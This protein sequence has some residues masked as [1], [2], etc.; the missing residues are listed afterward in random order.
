MNVV[1]LSLEY[2]NVPLIYGNYDELHQAKIS[3]NYNRELKSNL[4]STTNWRYHLTYSYDDD[5]GLSQSN[6]LKISYEDGNYVYQDYDLINS[7][8]GTLLDIK[9]EDVKAYYYDDVTSSWIEASNAESDPNIPMDIHLELSLKTIRYYELN[10]TVLTRVTYEELENE[11]RWNFIQG[12]EE[13][14]LEWVYI[15]EL[16]QEHDNIIANTI[17]PV[18]E[19]PFIVKEA[20]RVR[21]K[22]TKYI[23]DLIYPKGTIYYRVRPVGRFQITEGNSAQDYETVK[24]GVWSYHNSTTNLSD[25]NITKLVIDDQNEFS[26]DKNWIYGVN[27]AEDGKSVTTLGYFDGSLRG[28]QNLAYNTSDDISLIGESKFDYEGR[29]TISVI[30]APISGRN[31]I[32]QDN[33]NGGF[34]ASNFDKASPE[35]IPTSTNGSSQYFSPGNLLTDDRYRDRIPNAEGYVYSQVK[36][37]KDATGRVSEVGGIGSDF[38]IGSDHTTKYYY[39]TASNPELRRLFGDEVGYEDNYKKNIVYDANGQGTSSLIDNHGR[40]IA[41]AL[42]GDVADNLLDVD[43][44]Q[45]LITAPLNSANIVDTDMEKKSIHD[46]SH[47]YNS[48]SDYSF[49]YDMW[50]VVYGIVN[51]DPT[52]DTPLCVGCEYKLE[53]HVVDS[54]GNVIADNAGNSYKEL[55]FDTNSLSCSQL[56][57]NGTYI[58]GQT[59]EDLGTYSISVKGDYRAI[60]K[61]TVNTEAYY[62]NLESLVLSKIGTVDDYIT[63]N[64][65]EID[66]SGC[67]SSCD[68]ICYYQM[69]Y[70]VNTDDNPSIQWNDMTESEQTVEINQCLLEICNVDEIYTGSDEDIYDQTN[71]PDPGSAI[72]GTLANCQSI[73]AQMEAQIRP[74]GFEFLSSDFWDAVDDDLGG[75][76]LLYEGYP[77]GNNLLIDDVSYLED[78]AN[79]QEEWVSDLLPYHREY[80]HYEV[81]IELENTTLGG[82]NS[83]EFAAQMYSDGP[84]SAAY[85]TL[86]NSL[87]NDASSP[88]PLRGSDIEVLVEDE[89]G[90]YFVN[91][92]LAGSQNFEDCLTSGTYHDIDAYVNSV[93]ACQYYTTSP[94]VPVTPVPPVANSAEDFDKWNLYVGSYINRREI[95]I[96]WY[97]EYIDGLTDNTDDLYNIRGCLYFDD[98]NEIVVNPVPDADSD[99]N[100][101]TTVAEIENF[102]NDLQASSVGAFSFDCAD[103]CVAKVEFWI[104][105]FNADCISSMTSAELISLEDLL[106][107][108]CTTSCE[109]G[110]V[111]GWFYNNGTSEYNAVATFL[112]GF[113]ECGIE[114]IE[115]ESSN[116]TTSTVTV[117]PMNTCLSGLIDTINDVLFLNIGQSSTIT[118]NAELVSCLGTTTINIPFQS[119]TNIIGST[120][121]DT[122]CRNLLRFN[123]V[124]DYALVSIFDGN[125]ININ[126]VGAILDFSP[127]QTDQT[128]AYA[129]VEYTVG[130]ITEI[131]NVIIELAGCIQSSPVPFLEY[132]Q[133]AISTIPDCINDAFALGAYTAEQEYNALFESTMAE[134]SEEINCMDGIVEDYRRTYTLK[135]S[136]YTLFYYDQAGNLIATVPPEGVIPLT[137][138]TFDLAWDYSEGVWTEDTS[139]PD[140]A[141]QTTYQY[142]G[143]NQLISQST[144]DGGITHFYYDDLYRLRF[145][146][147]AKQ[148]A[149]NKFS[150]SQFDELGRVVEAGEGYDA[151]FTSNINS[152][153]NNDYYPGDLNRLDYVQTFYEEGLTYGN[154]DLAFTNNSQDNLRNRIGAVKSFIAT[155]TITNILNPVSVNFEKMVTLTTSYS[156]DIHGNVKEIVQT[157]SHLNDDGNYGNKLME[158]D[159]DLI[160]GNVNEVVYQR[161]Q[162]DEWRHAYDYDANNRLIRGFTSDDGVEWEMDAKYFYYLHGPLARVETG[163]D[164]VQGTDYVYNLQGWLKGVNSTTLQSDK[165]AGKDG[166]NLDLDKYSGQ[167]AYGY[168][169]GYF[170]DDY[171]SIGTTDYFASTDV[172]HNINGLSGVNGNLFNGNISTMVTALKDVNENRLAVLGN[173]YKYDQLNRI[174]SMDVFSVSN[175]NDF[176]TNNSFVGSTLY[177]NGAYATTYEYDLNG[178]LQY[179]TRK[180]HDGELM[181]DFEYHYHGTKINRLL[182]VNEQD[183]E[184]TSTTTVDVDIKDGQLPGNYDYDAIGQLIKDDQESITN[185]EWTVTGK[186]KSIEFF[187]KPNLEFYYDAMGNRVMKVEGSLNEIYAIYTYYIYDASGNVISTYTRKTA[188]RITLPNATDKWIDDDLSL[189]ERFIYGSKRLGVDKKNKVLRSK[190]YTIAIQSPNLYL[191]TYT[192]RVDIVDHSEN[193]DNT[194]REV[195]SKYYELSNHLGNVLEVVTDRKVPNVSATFYESD[196]V[197][198]SDYYPF[199]MLL[200]NR[201]ESTNAYRYGFNG[202]EKDDEVSGEGNSYDFG[203]RIYDSRVGRWLSV[204]PLAHKLPQY[205]PYA[206]CFNSPIY[207]IDKDGRF[208]EPWI[209]KIFESKWGI[210]KSIKF[211]D[212]IYS[213][214]NKSWNQSFDKSNN[215]TERGATL[216]VNLSKKAF[217]FVNIGGNGSSSGT[218][219]P[220]INIDE[221]ENVLIGTFHT[222][223]YGKNDGAL[224]GVFLPFSGGDFASMGDLDEAVSVVQSGENVYVLAMTSKTPTNLESAEGFFDDHFKTELNKQ[225]KAGLE[226]KDAASKAGEFAVK[227]TAKKFNMM[228][229]KGKNGKSLKKQK[230]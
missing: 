105:S 58:S 12:A 171:L 38:G 157:N 21:I 17:Y 225:I 49:T 93:W 73:L 123:S 161:G 40:V 54:D 167:D 222:H 120:S 110:N 214:M 212:E 25:L 205:S 230:L 178:N 20:T 8:S 201:H 89:Q 75:D 34:N 109:A 74:N 47:T 144:P 160:S 42:Y 215:S 70:T 118:L 227:K 213:Q 104:N 149:Q 44:E 23:F 30:P 27:F 84:W 196:I 182:R 78:E 112:T 116:I 218:F 170:K 100:G 142:N 43:S 146:R 61:L 186:V 229:F 62:S 188:S 197:S 59:P 177:N 190:E 24:V 72:I 82:V 181:D 121:D 154:I 203:A 36:F 135:E 18:S 206:Y 134:L 156:Y 221:K 209:I 99:G 4:V 220:D 143:L 52:I 5:S 45:V 35:V 10:S 204:D 39:E 148:A 64:M 115:I 141:L 117:I 81:C 46:F 145:S 28:R 56:G 128:I 152:S 11:I 102:G 180:D 83:N 80:C 137:Q 98:G 22:D 127:S 166:N 224:D 219:A 51:P 9:Y 111:G 207:F 202:M 119:P 168:S 175:D 185:I 228:Y 69:M 107:N 126:N 106:T 55:T 77:I 208:P 76:L 174:R 96:N 210:A 53:F 130:G 162:L 86:T 3:L 113:S 33:F 138:A 198:Y 114:I 158:Y 122:D 2:P 176:I 88:D 48:S 133:T 217:E 13:Y 223:P 31:F 14:D 153:I 129:N 139:N 131:V 16:S 211:S 192:S 173:N 1:D 140:H 57:P 216:T 95:Y 101:V 26:T 6:T 94:V 200:P 15:D 97:K 194:L 179:L 32:Y 67:Y 169:L 163:Q 7:G 189:S 132:S 165:D 172:L 29:Q 108:Y 184:L 164:K 136:Y 155:Y 150:Y 68:S 195:G 103:I 151:N 90:V 91:T 37:K 92:L 193:F 159:Y 71:G 147:N 50:G 19:F 183:A 60:K 79:F 187:N 199:G 125:P 65:G 191:P 63:Y 66:L 85:T 226:I 124:G 87:N 41:T